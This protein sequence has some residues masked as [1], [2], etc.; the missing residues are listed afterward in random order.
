MTITL[1]DPARLALDPAPGLGSR[2][3]LATR[4]KSPATG[5]LPRSWATNRDDPYTRSGVAPWMGSGPIPPR[6]RTP[7]VFV[8]DRP[9]LKNVG[10]GIAHHPESPLASAGE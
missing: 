5:S 3:P 4:C 9:R 2:E 7:K 6:T 8:P 10:R 1:P